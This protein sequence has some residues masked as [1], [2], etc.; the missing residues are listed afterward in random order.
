MTARTVI[1]ARY[2]RRHWLRNRPWWWPV[3][4]R[5]RLT[6]SGGLA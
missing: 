1:R 4:L 6:L 5:D 2:L 3:P